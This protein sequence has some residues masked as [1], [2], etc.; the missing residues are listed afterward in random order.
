MP[1]LEYQEA[2]ADDSIPLIPENDQANVIL[3][4]VENNDFEWPK[5]SGEMVHKLRW[6][7]TVMDD[8]PW[9][10]K[11]IQG[12]TSTN[13]KAH[14][15]CK[16]YNWAAAIMGRSPEGPLNTDDILTMK[17]RILVKHRESKKDGRVFM[18]VGDVMPP[19]EQT[20]APGLTHDPARD[21]EVF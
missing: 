6:Y 13:F 19:R 3:T 12:D 8:G 10:G 16:A 20:V 5:G 7:F 14:P 1:I 21:G 9:K 15:E 2:S 17:C 11:D 4:K 18:T